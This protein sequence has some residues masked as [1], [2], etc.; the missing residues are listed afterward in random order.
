MDN[1]NIFFNQ[2]SYTQHKKQNKIGHKF[3]VIRPS[4]GP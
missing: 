4:S 2:K 3:Q 1:V